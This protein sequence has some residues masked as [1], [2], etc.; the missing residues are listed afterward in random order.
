MVWDLAAGEQLRILEGHETMV[1]GVA[2]L[3]GGGT[4][5]SASADGALRSWNLAL[6][7]G[8]LLSWTSSNRYVREL[9]C[10]ER[11]LYRLLP[12]CGPES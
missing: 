8:Q 12:A 10:S 1:Q 3:S 2:F 9:S 7:L 5:V 4:I 11:E 6:D